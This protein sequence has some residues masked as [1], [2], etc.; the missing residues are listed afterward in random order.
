[1]QLFFIKKS[2]AHKL[3]NQRGS[4]PK[5]ESCRAAGFDGSFYRFQGFRHVNSVDLAHE[6]EIDQQCEH[7]CDQKR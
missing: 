5:R 3:K 7:H 2:Y 1:M 6:Q 4:P